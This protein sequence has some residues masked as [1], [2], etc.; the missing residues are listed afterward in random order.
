MTLLCLHMATSLLEPMES[1]NRTLQPEQMTISGML[2]SLKLVRA[3][4][5]GMCDD[6]KFKALVD[7]VESEIT[8]LDLEPLEIP[9]LCRP[10]NRF[11]GPTAA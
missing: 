1:L 5:Q 9:R 4:I 6:D 3:H 2:E 8:E 10:P 7:K 11:C